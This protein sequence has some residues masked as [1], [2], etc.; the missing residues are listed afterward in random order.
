MALGIVVSFLGLRGSIRSDARFNSRRPAFTPGKAPKERNMSLEPGRSPWTRRTIR[1]YSGR[2][3]DL[4][5]SSEQ[6][7]DSAGDICGIL[8]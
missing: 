3:A 4:L 7:L 6:Y 8:R 5:S 1:I 2:R